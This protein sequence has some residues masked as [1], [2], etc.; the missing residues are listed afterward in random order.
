MTPVPSFLV[1][2]GADSESLVVKL[3]QLRELLHYEPNAVVRTSLAIMIDEITAELGRRNDA[4]IAHREAGAKALVAEA[5]AI[6]TR[7]R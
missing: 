7:P 5:N 3:F 6:L 4:V 1:S 2:L